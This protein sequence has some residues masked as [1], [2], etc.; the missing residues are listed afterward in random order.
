MTLAESSTPSPPVEPYG[1]TPGA[2]GNVWFTELTG[3]AIGKLTLPHLNILNVTTFQAAPPSPT[4]P[5]CRTAAIRSAGWCLRP[6][7][8]RDSHD[9]PRPLRQLRG[10]WAEPTAIG[11]IGHCGSSGRACTATTTLPT[12]RAA[13]SPCRS[14][15]RAP[16]IRRR[17]E[18]YLGIQ[19]RTGGDVF[20]VEVQMPGSA[21][22]VPWHT[23]TTALGGSL[24]LATRSGR[25]GTWFRPTCEPLERHGVRILGPR[26]APRAPRRLENVS[27][28]DE[29][30]WY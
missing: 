16:L 12:G 2:D 24:A 3:S 18:R 7:R 28:S 23:G 11:G 5:I 1:V 4:S 13:S 27:G 15:S 22:F 25:R 17:R 14:A 8:G 19:A 29:L 6:A 30:S 9:R 10:G 21:G 26:R 20:D